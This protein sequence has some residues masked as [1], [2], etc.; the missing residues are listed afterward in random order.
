VPK[1]NFVCKNCNFSI[2][3]IIETNI[4]KSSAIDRMIQWN[5]EN[6]VKVQTSYWELEFRDGNRGFYC[7]NCRLHIPACNEKELF[8]WLSKNN[9]LDWEN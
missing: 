5:D 6:D 8:D 2:L 1:V 4:T 3:C 7:G 9:M